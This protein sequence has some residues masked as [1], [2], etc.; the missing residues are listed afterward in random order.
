MFEP[1]FTKFVTYI[2]ND[3]EQKP[4]HQLHSIATLTTAYNLF[5]K[6]MSVLVYCC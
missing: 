6:F 2:P 5:V 3:L 1:T 4:H